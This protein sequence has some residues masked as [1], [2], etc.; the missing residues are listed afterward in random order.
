MGKL[1][2]IGFP[3]CGKTTYGKKLAK[4][5][6]LAFQDTDFLMEKKLKLS[7][8]DYYRRYGER[9]FRQ[10]EYEVL[11]QLEPFCG[12]IATGGGVVEEERSM[13]LLQ[14]FGRIIFLASPFPLISSR[15]KQ[16]KPAFFAEADFE[17]SFLAF[18]ERRL[19]LY[20]AYADERVELCAYG[21]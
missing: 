20:E 11:K 3:A 18:I 10:E 15:L 17:E 14:S 16:S 4:E 12:V 1:I 7:V 9:K 19:P 8:R 6:N 2:L 21:S 5:R 13:K